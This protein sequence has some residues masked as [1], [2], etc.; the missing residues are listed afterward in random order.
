MLPPGGTLDLTPETYDYISIA[1]QELHRIAR[2]DPLNAPILNLPTRFDIP[3]YKYNSIVPDNRSFKKIAKN[4]YY[5]KLPALKNKALRNIIYL[6]DQVSNLSSRIIDSFR[7]R[8]RHGYVEL[9]EGRKQRKRSIKHI[10]KQAR[11]RSRK[12]SRKQ[13]RKKK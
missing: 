2:L 1:R 10:R 8:R 12:H 11:K 3:I 6:R 7:R 9:G 13:E 4:V 5:Y